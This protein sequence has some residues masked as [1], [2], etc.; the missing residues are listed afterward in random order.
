MKYKGA[1][2]FG[3]A[4]VEAFIELD[5]DGEFSMIYDLNER[6]E[7]PDYRYSSSADVGI[8]DDIEDLKKAIHDNNI[9]MRRPELNV[10][11]V[12][13]SDKEQTNG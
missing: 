12:S 10:E 8:Y 4:K 13:Y 2:I 9:F 6:E 3:V 7:I 1:E 5:E 11:S